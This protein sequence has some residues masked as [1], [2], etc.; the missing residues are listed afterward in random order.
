MRSLRGCLNARDLEL[1]PIALFQMMNA[2]VE[3]QQELEAMVPRSQTHI[4]R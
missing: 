1:E 3:R 2:P 4:I